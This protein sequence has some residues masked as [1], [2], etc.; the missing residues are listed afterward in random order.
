LSVSGARILVV[1]DEPAILRTVRANLARHGFR[2]DT[3]AT[4]QEALEHSLE[5]PDLILLDLGLPD[6]DGLELI[7]VIR[8]QSNMPIIVLSARGAERDKVRALDLGADDYLTKPF[9]LDELYARIRVALRHSTRLPGNEPVFRTGGLEVDVEHR[10]V[11]VD[12]QEIHLTPTEY[13]LLLVLARNAD[14][15]VTDAM[16]LRDVWG[17]QYG[18]E[19]HYLHVYV[20]RLR[21]KLER[22][23]QRPRYLRTEPGVGY[24]LLAED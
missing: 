8:E 19:D 22:D 18:D 2:V 16:L 7:R 20:A 17:P 15:V 10:R 12:D 4:A 3:A 24:R 21:K 13:T 6:G 23:P 14:R 9:G 11:T 1:D 5:R